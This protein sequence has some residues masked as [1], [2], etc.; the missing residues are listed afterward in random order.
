M[1]G[2][3]IT[4]P[5]WRRLGAVGCRDA[6]RNFGLEV[7]DELAEFLD[8]VLHR[9]AAHEKRAFGL[10]D[11]VI[12]ELGLDRLGAF[13]HLAI[14]DPKA[15]PL[16]CYGLTLLETGECQGQGIGPSVSAGRLSTTPMSVDRSCS[17]E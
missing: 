13:E 4:I 12:H 17:S 3:P 8:A 15:A 6:P 7:V 5:R 2:W 9:G 14:S 10:V 11:V 16:P 1:S